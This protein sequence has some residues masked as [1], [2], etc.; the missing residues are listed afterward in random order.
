MKIK[1]EDKSWIDCD[2]SGKGEAFLASSF[3]LQENMGF[4]QKE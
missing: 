2:I 3:L 1:G 4:F